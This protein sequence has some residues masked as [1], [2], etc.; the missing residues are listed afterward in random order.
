MIKLYLYDYTDYNNELHIYELKAK[1]TDNGDFQIITY[2]PY[3][4]IDK[5][6]NKNCLDDPNF[7]YHM[8]FSLY[9][10]KEEIFIKKICEK[11]EEKIAE[12]QKKIEKVRSIKAEVFKF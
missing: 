12:I 5:V 6:I 7:Y 2:M 11:L 10:N 1:I 4:L 3:F 9:E 8:M